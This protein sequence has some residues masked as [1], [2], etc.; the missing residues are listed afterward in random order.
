MLTYLLGVAATIAGAPIAQIRF[1]LLANAIFLPVYVNGKGPFLFE[2]DT[3]SEMSMVASETAARIG[4]P[5]AGTM[6]G[7]GAGSGATSMARIPH[8]VLTLP[9]G[10]RLTTSEGATVSMAG[11]WPLVG[12]R[13]DGDVGYDGLRR[14]VLEIDYA[15]RLLTFYD[16]A[17]YRYHGKGVAL[18]FQLWGDY[19]PQVAGAIVVPGRPP[20]PVRYTLDTGAG[21]TI[22]TAPLVRGHGLL[23]SALRTLPSPSRGVGL[24]E[25]PDVVARMDAF[26]IGPYELRRPIAALSRDTVGSLTHESLGVNLGGNILRRFTVIVDYPHGR[27][28][29]EPNLHFQEPFAAD[30]SGLVLRAEGADFR[31]FVVAAVVPG[32]PAADAGLAPGDVIVGIEGAD[33]THYALWQLQDVLKGSGRLCR[34]RVRRGGRVSRSTLQLRALL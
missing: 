31:T 32:S 17:T 27:L 20:I 21:G 14:Y 1:A 8:L 4:L 10:L 15:R 19:D 30:A 26:R 16:P 28:I 25:S 22:V 7:M 29:L 24:G 6:N 33:I 9:G 3:G 23:Q 18:P 13:I 2:L 11:L 12:R 34:L 5:T